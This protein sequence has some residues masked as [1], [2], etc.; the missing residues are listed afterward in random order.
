MLPRTKFVMSLVLLTSVVLNLTACFPDAPEEPST[1]SP[2]PAPTTEQVT[3]LPDPPTPTQ[4]PP[5]STPRPSSGATPGPITVPEDIRV[6]KGYGRL[7]KSVEVALPAVFQGSSY[8]LPADLARLANRQRFDFS[9]SQANLLSEN[10]FVVSPAEWLE[11]FQVYEAVRYQELPVFIT[12]DSVYH[13]YH[14]LFDKLLRDLERESLAPTLE[15][16]TNALAETA[17]LQYEQ[18]QGTTVADAA[19]RA[20]AYFVVAQQLLM[21]TPPP[22]PDPIREEVAGE[23]ALINAHDGIFMSPLLSLPEA[24][25]MKLFCDPNAAP[26]EAEKFY[27][28]DY[29]Q[30]VPRGHYT[31]DAQLERYFRTMMWYGR[32]NLRLKHRRETRIALLITRTIRQTTVGDTPAATLWASIYDPT[33]FLV[34]KS[35]DL[36]FHEYGPLMDAVFGDDPDITVFSEDP[37]IDAFTAVARELPPP[38]INSMW[39]YIWEDKDDVTQGFRFMG[40]RFVLDAYIFEQLTHREVP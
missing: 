30:Y 28:E 37:Y 33:V 24:F 17:R 25:E 23:L 22:I 40:Q 31:R 6:N 19:R 21:E 35:D 29:S 14:L 2:P 8:A 26:D 11:F 7:Y 15:I 38:Q 18:A 5:T 3:T 16:L 1:P 20:W 39:V 4:A 27:C 36:S 32:I 12:T 13:V 9:A 10:G 34:G